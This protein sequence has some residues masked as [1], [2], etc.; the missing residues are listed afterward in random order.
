MWAAKLPAHPALPT[1]AAAAPR[2][3][4]PGAPPHLTITHY[5]ELAAS[6]G[7]VLSRADV[8]N[9]RVVS[10]PEVKARTGRCERLRC[11]RPVCLPSRQQQRGPLLAPGRS[12]AAPAG[13]SDRPARPCRRPQP[14]GAPVQ[15]PPPPA[16][17]PAPPPGRAGDKLRPG[18]RQSM[19]RVASRA[20]PP[21]PAGARAAGADQGLLHRR[22]VLCAGA[23]LQPRPGALRLPA[24]AAAAGARAAGRAG[25]R[26]AAG[27]AV[28]GAGVPGASCGQV[29]GAARPQGLNG[30]EMWKEY[31]GCANKVSLEA[32][33]GRERAFDSSS[34]RRATPRR[35]NAPWRSCE[36]FT[37]GA[38]STAAFPTPLPPGCPP[39]WLPL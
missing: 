13:G 14:P 22:A 8:I 9:D 30:A 35:C 16:L 3:F 18:S 11:M 24:A 34:T 17:R 32:V 33:Q 10:M 20:G 7:V 27:A 39:P 2:R 31:V 21:P 28:G 23:Q 15:A 19:L 36:G 4:G 37:L 6:K 5:T 12:P 25:G 26:G 29:L 38:A 1:T